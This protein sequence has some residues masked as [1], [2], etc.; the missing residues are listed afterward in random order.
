MIETYLKSFRVFGDYVEIETYYP[1]ILES[2]KITKV[3]MNNF[4]LR[5]YCKANNISQYY[6][7][8]GE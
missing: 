3:N 1:N 8:L 5:K 6:Y 2:N 4:N 7:T